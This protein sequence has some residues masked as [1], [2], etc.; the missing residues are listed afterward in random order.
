M[1]MHKLHIG[2]IGCGTVGSGVVKLLTERKNFFRDK[3]GVELII[4]KICDRDLRSRKIPRRYK[5][6]FTRNF[7]EVLSDPSVDVVVELIGGLHPAEEI[8]FG[9]LK[10]NKHVVTANKELLAREGQKLFSEAIKRRRNIYFEAA[11]C[12]GIPL[13]SS[14]TEGL[15]GNRFNGLYGIINGTC[16]FILSE[17]A[18]DR[19]SFA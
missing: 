16:N 4:R 10:N 5:N 18:N 12:A 1:K 13:I 7:R 9:A 17:M 6:T 14:I 3:F 19:C 11:V 2:L 8:M 15:A